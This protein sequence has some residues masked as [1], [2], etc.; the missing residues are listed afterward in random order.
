[1]RNICIIVNINFMK[2]Y[3]QKNAKQPGATWWEACD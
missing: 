2:F 3:G 1:M